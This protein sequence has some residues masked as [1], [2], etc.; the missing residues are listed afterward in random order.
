VT[1]IFL[2]LFFFQNR[3]SHAQPQ[4]IFYELPSSLQTDI[5]LHLTKDLLSQVSFFRGAPLACLSFIA[6]QLRPLAVPPGE[7]I[8]TEGEV[9][10]TMYFL[11]RGL[12]EVTSGLRV[13]S[14]LEEGAVFGEMALL[15]PGQPRTAT[16]R[17][18]VFSD[19]FE[20]SNRDLDEVLKLWPALRDVL[21]ATMQRRM[22][23]MKEV[24][25]RAMAAELDSGKSPKPT[26]ISTQV[27]S[28]REAMR[29]D[30]A[31]RA[32]KKLASRTSSASDATAEAAARTE[33]TEEL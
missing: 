16:I 17:A 5:S 23:Q 32:W 29:K 25:N 21:T 4:E 30:V 14:L 9:G 6:K 28:E 19:V 11:M 1:N 26:L 12:L 31:K 18:L 33:E 24:T 3:R 20:L 10:E 22:E 13:V 15:M 7:R 8:V 27:Q 2:T